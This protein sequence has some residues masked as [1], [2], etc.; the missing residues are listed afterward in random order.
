[1]IDKLKFMI[2][3]SESNP[4]LKAIFLKVAEMPEDKQEKMLELIELMVKARSD[5]E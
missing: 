3:Q 5:N 1:M 4:K 2:D